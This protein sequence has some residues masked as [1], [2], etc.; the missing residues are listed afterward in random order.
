M[1]EAEH[2]MF[3]QI[4]VWRLEGLLEVGELTCDKPER[5]L[6]TSSHAVGHNAVRAIDF[7]LRN[8]EAALILW[9]PFGQ[10]VS[11]KSDPD[12]AG[13]APAGRSMGGEAT[14]QYR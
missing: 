11:T 13:I 3:R 10:R 8:P 6:I 9:P 5:E 14:D 12:V 7:I 2:Y 1:N 4:R